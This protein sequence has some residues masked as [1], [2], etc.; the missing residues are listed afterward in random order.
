MKKG[1]RGYKMNNEQMV[2]Q[3]EGLSKQ[4]K[5]VNALQGLNLQVAQHSIFG[6]LGPNGGAFEKQSG[7]LD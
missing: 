1:S 6:F 3:T 4:Y 2:I 5:G 7:I